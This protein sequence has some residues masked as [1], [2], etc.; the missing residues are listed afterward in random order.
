MKIQVKEKKL[1][2][3]LIK[4]GHSK[5]SFSKSAGIGQSTF[6]Q[7]CNG[8]RNPSPKTAKKIVEALKLKFDDIF[9]VEN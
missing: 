5:R 8:D 1:E 9:Y 3:V 7:V 6:I 4:Q 2:E